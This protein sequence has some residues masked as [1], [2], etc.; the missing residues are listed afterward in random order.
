MRESDPNL[1]D[2]YQRSNRRGP[3]TDEE[4]YSR[5]GSDHLREERG[6]LWPQVRDSIVKESGGG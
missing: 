6:K 5:T 4:S 2:C 3:Q 1:D